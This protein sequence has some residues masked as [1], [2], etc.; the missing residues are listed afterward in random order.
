MLVNNDDYVPKVSIITA[1]FNSA[2]TIRDT[3][4]SFLLQ[5]HPSIKH[6]IIDG[7]STDSTMKIVKSFYPNLA[8][9]ISEPDEGI[10]DATAI[11]R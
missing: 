10:Y 4:E 8:H 1:A 6:I 9:V 3:I 7:G 2:V 5:Y 11:N